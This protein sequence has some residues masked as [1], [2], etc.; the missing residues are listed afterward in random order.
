M[1]IDFVIRQLREE[2]KRLDGIIETLERL[3]PEGQAPTKPKRRGRKSMDEKGRQ[4]VS[5]RMKQYWERR[6]QRERGASGER[7][8]SDQA[9]AVA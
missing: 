4:E 6:R 9:R 1:D 3:G 7:E 8:Q 2:R 5:K